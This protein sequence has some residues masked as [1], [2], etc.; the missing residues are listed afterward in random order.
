MARKPRNPVARS[1]LLRKG[2]AHRKVRSGERMRSKK[3]LRE[4]AGHSAEK[5]PNK[6][7]E[8]HEPADAAP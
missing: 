1:P 3:A 5:T 4:E 8:S 2:G 7:P 6:D